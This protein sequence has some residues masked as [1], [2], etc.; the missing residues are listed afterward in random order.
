[1]RF[2]TLP[3]EPNRFKGRGTT[4]AFAEGIRPF[5]TMT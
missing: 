3:P 5:G 1:M 2:E 4:P